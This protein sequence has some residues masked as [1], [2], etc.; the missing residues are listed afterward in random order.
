MLKVSQATS[1]VCVAHEQG[2][3]CV[4]ISAQ[5]ISSLFIVEVPQIPMMSSQ[6][7]PCPHKR[8]L[9]GFTQSLS[10]HYFEHHSEA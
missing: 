3:S 8:S 9:Y 4:P 1:V 7:F 5:E 10:W 6:S 2:Q